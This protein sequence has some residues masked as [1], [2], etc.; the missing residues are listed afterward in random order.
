MSD[1]LTSPLT[2]AAFASPIDTSQWGSPQWLANDRPTTPPGARSPDPSEASP[3]KYYLGDLPLDQAPEDWTATLKC[4][5]KN[6]VIRWLKLVDQVL[7]TFEEQKASHYMDAQEL[8]SGGKMLWEQ[9]LS[10]FRVE[11]LSASLLA[12]CPI[13]AFRFRDQRARIKSPKQSSKQLMAK[14][15][16]EADE[17][18]YEA[19]RARAIAKEASHDGLYIN[20]PTNTPI[21]FDLYGFLSKTYPGIGTSS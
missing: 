21:T 8:R 15:R 12:E 6:L 9:W 20:L 14:F 18:K 13:F 10:F 19:K 4:F 2:G 1:P 16:L 11:T 17:I 3:L 5:T 7:T